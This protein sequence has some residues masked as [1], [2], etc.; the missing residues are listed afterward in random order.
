MN[1]GKSW[2]RWNC[3]M[4]LLKQHPDQRQRREEQGIDTLATKDAVPAAGRRRPLREQ[5]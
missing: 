1:L 3:Q 2:R 4:A 5:H